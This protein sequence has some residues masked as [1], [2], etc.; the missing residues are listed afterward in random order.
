MAPQVKM[1]QGMSEDL[2][3]FYAA[4]IV[5]ALQ[6]LHDGGTVYRDLKPENVFLDVQAR[7]RGGGWTGVGVGG[8][9]RSRP[10]MGGEGAG[11]VAARAWK[12]RPAE[13]AGLMWLNPLTPRRASP[14]HTLCAQGFVKLGDFGFA[15]VLE[16]QGRTYTFCGTP[17]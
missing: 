11:A 1:L 12:A 16:G 8:G 4:S 3:R 15:K 13:L 14:P 7:G 2:A 9:V 5:L 10:G 17:G 6:Y